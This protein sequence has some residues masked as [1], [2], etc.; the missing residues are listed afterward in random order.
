[1]KNVSEDISFLKL[2][3]QD[4]SLESLKSSLL[5]D[6]DAFVF[7]L[8]VEKM[9]PIWLNDFFYKRMSYTH[10]DLEKLT[11]EEFLKMFHPK[12]LANL[13]HRIANIDRNEKQGLRSIYQLRTN[14]NEWIYMLTSSKVHKRNPDGSIKHLLGFATEI[15]ESEFSR[16]IKRIQNIGEK[17][18]ENLVLCKLSKRETDIIRLITHGLTDKEIAEN[19][20]ISIHTTKTHRK[21]IISKLG[22]KNTAALVRFAV[23]NDID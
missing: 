1:M 4:S 22:L 10:E 5:N 13:R 16:H 7:I 19:L 18:P 8:D 15:E 12:S 11:S 6:I 2:L 9:I 14:K 3:G 17:S 20:K 21:R 23:E